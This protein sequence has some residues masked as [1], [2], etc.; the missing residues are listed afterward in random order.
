M[1]FELE[2]LIGYC[3]SDCS[4]HIACLFVIVKVICAI[5][6]GNL[7]ISIKPKGAFNLK[8]LLEMIFS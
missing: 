3:F 8:L 5:S 4:V 2:V 6:C 1:C 7:T